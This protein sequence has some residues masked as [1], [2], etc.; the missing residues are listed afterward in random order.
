MLRII[1]MAKQGAHSSNHIQVTTGVLPMIMNSTPV[2]ST[3]LE[4]GWS[5]ILMGLKNIRNGTR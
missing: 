5:D 4:Q 2:M 1:A 3:G